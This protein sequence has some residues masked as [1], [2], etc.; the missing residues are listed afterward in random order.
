MSAA[1]VV[2]EA[3]AELDVAVVAV[4]EAGAVA[5]AE[6][7][8]EAEAVIGFGAAVKVEAVGAVVGAGFGTESV[9]KFH[10]MELRTSPNP[11]VTPGYVE[12]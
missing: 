9:S 5:E 8:V 11:P 6:D 1:A 10:P 2:I 4:A 12:C 3:A 7:G